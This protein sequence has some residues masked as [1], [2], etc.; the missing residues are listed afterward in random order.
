MLFSKGH[1]KRPGSGRTVQNDTSRYQPPLRVRRGHRST[2]VRYAEKH[3]ETRQAHFFFFIP[4]ACLCV[5]TDCLLSVIKQSFP[6][7]PGCQ[8]SLRASHCP[9]VSHCASCKNNK[10]HLQEQQSREGNRSQVTETG[11]YISSTVSF[12]NIGNM[13]YSKCGLVEQYYAPCYHQDAPCDLYVFI[14]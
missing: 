6:A 10:K 12:L 4:F 13:D 9:C 5:N 2:A 8:R 11:H 7:A 14:K 3:S 1:K